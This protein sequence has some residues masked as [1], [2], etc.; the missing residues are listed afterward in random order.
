MVDGATE[1][2]HA[3]LYKALSEIASGRYVNKHGHYQMMRGPRCIDTAR[4]ALIAAGLT[5]PTCSPPTKKG[6]ED[7]MA[8]L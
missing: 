7:G 2:Q 8:V 6:H 3:I 5:W 1:Q 4:V